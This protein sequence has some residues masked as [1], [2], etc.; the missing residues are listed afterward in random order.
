MRAWGEVIVDEHPAT[1]HAHMREAEAAAGRD[2]LSDGGAFLKREI[3]VA[4][5]ETGH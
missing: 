1:T 3:A 4:T 2:S 5:G